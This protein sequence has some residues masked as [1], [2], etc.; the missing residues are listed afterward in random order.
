MKTITLIIEGVQK[1]FLDMENKVLLLDD[2]GKKYGETHVYYNL[3]TPAEAI[4]LLCIN[5][6]EFAKDLATSHE[7]GIFYKVQQVDIDLE[8]S[9]LILPL[10][11]HD[12]VVT[13][14]I[15]GSGDVGNVLLGLAI[16]GFTGGLGAA[17]F[18][19]ALIGNTGLTGLAAITANVGSAIGVS[20]VLQ[21]VTGLLSPQPT[22][23]S[24]M[25]SEGSFTN[26][27]SGP[28]SLEKG[29]DGKQSY[30][31]TGATNST[32]LGKTIP[33]AYGKVLAGSLLIGAKIET[34]TTSKTNI[35]F[36]R[37]PNINT[38]TLNGDKIKN[39]FTDAGGIEVKKKKITANIGKKNGTK[40]YKKKKTVNLLFNDDEQSLVTGVTNPD[41]NS[42]G[43]IQ[44]N[45]KKKAKRAS[46]AFCVAFRIKGLIDRLAGD[47]TAFI[48]G[49]ITYQVIIKAA[50]SNNIVGQHQ[51]TIQGL[52]KKQQGLQYIVKTPFVTFG[53][54]G[55]YR[56][57]VKI[58]DFS[59]LDTHCS[60]SVQE[61]G[62][63]LI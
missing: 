49:F 58:I 52:M 30:A 37:N 33:V 29:A 47:D 25:D 53:D 27:T 24:G 60:F 48:D 57:F 17:G 10:G 11:S 44:A 9:D 54:V 39:V 26:F 16:I 38:F 62:M 7:Q 45:S 21:G 18:G 50:G 32:G 42:T 19:G 63:G 15:S 13:P 20:L 12:L 61:I 5:Y 4:K 3:K 34:Q 55:K 23:S 46:R 36:F 8:L 56:A 14:V 41:D 51:M 2:L 1:Q 35:K 6:P 28:A 31:Y 59:V 22:L 40:Y 43:T